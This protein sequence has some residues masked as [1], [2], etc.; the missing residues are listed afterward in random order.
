[1]AHSLGNQIVLNAFARDRFG[2]SAS[3]IAELVCAA[4]DVPW[5]TFMNL[6][7]ELPEVARG[8]T[9]YASSTDM[10]LGASMWLNGSVRAGSV[11]AQGPI[12]IKGIES[13]DVTS[14]GPN[15]FSFDFNHNIV[16]T[17]I[18]LIGDLSRLFLDRMISAEQEHDSKHPPNIRSPIIRGAPSGIEPPKYWKFP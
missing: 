7:N 18:S 10:A 9:L 11:T 6:G 13:I 15:I 8:V 12:Q 2:G 16:M 17:D 14:L 4:P 1:M 3:P 5:K